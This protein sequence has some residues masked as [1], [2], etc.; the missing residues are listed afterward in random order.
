MSVLE[1]GEQV[2][3]VELGVGIAGV[4]GRVLVDQIRLLL[5]HTRV[6]VGILTHCKQSVDSLAS[7][8]HTDP[9]FFI[10]RPKGLK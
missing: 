10:S 8:R 6:A 7:L 4:D 2:D 3:L 5:L 9:S 1:L